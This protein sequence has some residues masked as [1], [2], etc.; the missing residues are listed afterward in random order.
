MKR[1][2][3]AAAVAALTL[4][5]AQAA[6]IAWATIDGYE[7]G[8]LGSLPN[9]AHIAPNFQPGGSQAGVLRVIATFTSP[10]NS[11]SYSGSLLSFGDN[12]NGHATS[13]PTVWMRDGILHLGIGDSDSHTTK[14]DSI[15]QLLDGQKHELAL[16][17]ERTTNARMNASFFVDGVEIY[18]ITNAAV[19]SGDWWVYK[20]VLG[21]KVSM[22]EEA[23]GIA[24]GE[25]FEVAYAQATIDDLRQTYS[26]PEPTALALLALG[27]A[28]VALRRRVA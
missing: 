13:S 12:E 21:N 3:F 24:F 5:A 23:S 18:T 10:S 25:D 22:D 19:A 6:N 11:N 9:G 16:A 7:A 4:G 20:Y 8:T 15:A 2:L 27:V 1:I 17:I 14:D 28:G 26:I